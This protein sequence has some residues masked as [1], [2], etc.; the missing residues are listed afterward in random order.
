MFSLHL[1]RPELSVSFPKKSYWVNS[2]FYTLM[3]RVS[4][5]L[6]GFGSVFFLLRLLTKDDFGIWALFLTVTSIIEVARNG[7][8]QNALVK[9]LASAEKSDHAAITTASVALNF[10]LTIV[11]IIILFVLSKF[12]GNAWNALVLNAMLE[13]YI[14]TTI[15]LIGLSQLTFIQQANF[16]FRGNF[17]G[18]FFRQGSLF[19]YILYVFISKNEIT[20]IH[21]AWFQVISA[22]LGGVVSFF[23]GRKYLKLSTTVSRE[24]MTKL[25]QFGKFTLGTNLGTMLYRN[26][27]KIM[28]GT[29]LKSPAAVGAYD[30]AVRIANLIEVPTATMAAIVFPQ[31]A[32]R[33]ITEGNKAIKYLYERSVGILLAIIFPIVLVIWLLAEPGIMLVAGSDYLESV[34][35]LR[36]ML[37]FGLLV[38]FAR[39]FGTVLDSMGKPKVNLY[40]VVISLLLNTGFCFLLI[41]KFGVSGAA[42][43]VL[44]TTLIR[45]TLNLVVLRKILD[46]R[47]FSILIHSKNF[48]EQCFSFTSDF[49]KRILHI[50]L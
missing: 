12:L 45:V 46:V 33:A 20:L 6:F 48:Y 18:N 35:L 14:L 7:L 36:L 27:D 34:H 22:L 2:G 47:L 23:F 32:K 39:Q 41:P 9:Y 5:M 8:I 40:F 29:L 17:W 21:L 16:D 3:E 11:S 37:I 24:W 26:I 4:F 15:A 19:F 28:L 1:N 30:L 44:I 10:I 50:L 43:S 49:L 38:P 31:S 42:Y 13:I 25:F